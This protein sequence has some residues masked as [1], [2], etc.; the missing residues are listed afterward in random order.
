VL[1]YAL[2]LLCLLFAIAQGCEKG[3]SALIMSVCP[4]VCMEK[5]C[6]RCKDLRDILGWVGFTKIFR[7]NSDLVTVRRS[8]SRPAQI[9]LNPSR[10]E[11][12]FRKRN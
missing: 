7:E 10:A 9:A 2:L 4:S 5:F 11:K 1:L 12:L 3:L 6:T 8:T